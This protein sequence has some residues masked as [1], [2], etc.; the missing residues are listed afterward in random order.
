MT[1]KE[2]LHSTLADI[3]ERLEKYKR[4]KE[5]EMKL[6]EYQSWIHGIFNRAAIVS[7]FNKRAKYPENPLETEQPVDISKLSPDELAD[8]QIKEL[9]KLDLSARAALGVDKKQD[10]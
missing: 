8:L 2:F 5:Y 9:Q 10:G 7:S 3:Q 1:K 4:E 6:M